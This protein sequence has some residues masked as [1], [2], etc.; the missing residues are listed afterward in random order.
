MILNRKDEYKTY[1]LHGITG[2]GKTEVYMQLC[3]EIIKEGKCIIMLV[4]E[5]SL[6]TQIVHRFYSRFGNDVAIFH[7]NLSEGEKFDEYKKIMKGEVHIVVGTRSAIFTP[8]NNLGLIIIDEEHSSNYKQD[9]NPR[10]HALDIAK[11]RANYHNCPVILGSATPSLES[12]ARAEKR[13]MSI[14]LCVKE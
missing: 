1:L 4:P 5:I 9:N 11:W 8:I 2:S 14:F 10:Y 6:T 12:M 7:S 3:E 13:F